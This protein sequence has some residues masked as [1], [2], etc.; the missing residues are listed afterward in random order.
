MLFNSYTSVSRLIYTEPSELFR[1]RLSEP[2]AS[3]SVVSVLFNISIHRGYYLAVGRH[4]APSDILPPLVKEG[5]NV[6][7]FCPS[8]LMRGKMS[9]G[10]ECLEILSQ[11]VP[12]NGVTF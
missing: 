7:K 11:N 10:A 9:Q 2:I 8:I 12:P 3:E 5:Q 4:F 1:L 6:Q